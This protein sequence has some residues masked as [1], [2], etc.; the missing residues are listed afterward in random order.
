MDKTTKPM[1]SLGKTIIYAYENNSFFAPRI[2]SKFFINKNDKDFINKLVQLNFIIINV[3]KNIATAILPIQWIHFQ[4]FKNEETICDNYGRVRILI[5]VK[6]Q[7]SYLNR[8]FNYE[9][10]SIEVDNRKQ[11]KC[12][13]KDYYSIL[14]YFEVFCEDDKIVVFHP[15][16][17]Y[18]SEN[19]MTF[20][21]DNFN[22]TNEK[23]VD[24]AKQE[25]ERVL[26]EYLPEWENEV[27][28]WDN[29]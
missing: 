6:N 5:D 8:R 2:E 10:N 7:T 18:E 17:E 11:I 21:R 9:I 12:T 23:L 26:Q 1:K 22:L 14:S 24:I 13:I 16:T 29:N 4:N 19:R 15:A 3:K 25:C 20:K 27:A 28:Y